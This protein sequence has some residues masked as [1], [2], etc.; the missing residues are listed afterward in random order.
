MFTFNHYRFSLE[1]KKLQDWKDRCS[2]YPGISHELIHYHNAALTKWTTHDSN[3]S[4][5]T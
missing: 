1:Y 2:H 4:H 5:K 3:K